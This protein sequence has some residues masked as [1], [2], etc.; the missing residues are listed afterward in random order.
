[1]LSYVCRRVPGNAR[2]P[3]S[4]PSRPRARFQGRV[5]PASAIRSW[6]PTFGLAAVHRDSSWNGRSPKAVNATK[7]WGQQAARARLNSRV[8]TCRPLT[9]SLKLC[10]TPKR[11]NTA[12]LPPLLSSDSHCCLST[13]THVLLFHSDIVSWTDSQN[14]L[15]QQLDQST[16]SPPPHEPDR[17]TLL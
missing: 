14:T 5:L 13:S 15:D 7:W 17:R 16:P 11:N 4:A 6:S 9:S 8:T 1:M 10:E 3:E 2:R 12:V